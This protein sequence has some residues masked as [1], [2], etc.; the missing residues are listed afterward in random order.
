MR[1]LSIYVAWDS[2]IDQY[3]LKHPER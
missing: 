1:S 2:P 3:F